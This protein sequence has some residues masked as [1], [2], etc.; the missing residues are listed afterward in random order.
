MKSLHHNGHSRGKVQRKGGKSTREGENWDRVRHDKKK[1]KSS[2]KMITSLCPLHQPSDAGKKDEKASS[3]AIE[4]K[5]SKG[6]GGGVAWQS[7]PIKGDM[8][9]ISG[10]EAL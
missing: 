6:E 4:G 10:S 7:K 8:H 3:W 2:R 1:K 5:E 9:R